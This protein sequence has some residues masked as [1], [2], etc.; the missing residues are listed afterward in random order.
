M[1]RPA[2]TSSQARKQVLTTRRTA[3]LERR[4]TGGGGVYEIKLTVDGEPFVD[5][6]FFLDIL[7][8]AIDGLTLIVAEAAVSVVGST[9]TTVQYRNVTNGDVDMLSTLITI[10]AGDLKSRAAGT[11]SVID[12]PNAGVSLDDQIAIEWT[13]GT[14]AE[15]LQAILK[16]G[17]V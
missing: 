11:R 15:G 9:A 1:T 3:N 7:D 14:A 5:G 2:L 16:F 6:V 13:A 17:Q 8:E 12:S 4:P 10:D